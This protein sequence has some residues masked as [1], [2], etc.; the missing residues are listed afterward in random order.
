M[1]QYIQWPLIFLGFIF[2]IASIVS[3]FYRPVKNKPKNG[4]ESTILTGRVYPSIISC[5]RNRVLILT[6]FFAYYAFILNSDKYPKDRIIQLFVSIFFMLAVAHNL[7]N[8]VFN[9]QEE[10]ILEGREENPGF[11]QTLF[12]SPMELF[13][14][15]VM[16]F[17]I[18][19]AF[20]LIKL[21]C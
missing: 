2:L 20:F 4:I 16:I 11:L 1:I 7:F 18:F 17:L 5:V 6:S 19:A 14:T 12:T 10:L 8:Y 15:I 21:D 13:F 3:L 9:H